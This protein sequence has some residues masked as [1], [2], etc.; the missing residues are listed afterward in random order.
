VHWGEP[1]EIVNLARSRVTDAD[2]VQV[3]RLTNLK[4]LILSGTKVTDAGLAHLSGIKNLRT[5]RPGGTRFT[6]AGIRSL[7]RTLPA[8]EVER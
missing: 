2:L 5:L 7:M 4:I 3:S 1:D 8:L 6:E